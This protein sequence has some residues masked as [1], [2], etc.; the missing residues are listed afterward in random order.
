MPCQAPLPPLWV[1]VTSFAVTWLVPEPATLPSVMYWLALLPLWLCFTSFTVTL[2]VPVLPH[3]VVPI[4]APCPEL[5]PDWV[6]VKSC[7][8]TLVLPL[9]LLLPMTRSRQLPLPLCVC[10][11]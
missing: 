10:D 3:H 4:H 2:L 9:P 8:L 7:I 1:C 5:L 11:A 6:W